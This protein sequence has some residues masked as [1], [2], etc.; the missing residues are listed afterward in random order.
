[1]KNR[2]FD[3]PNLKLTPELREKILNLRRSL[4]YDLNILH[5]KDKLEEEHNIHNISLSYETV[6]GLL[7]KERLCKAEKIGDFT[8]RLKRMPKVIR[9]YLALLLISSLSIVYNQTLVYTF[10]VYQTSFV[11]SIHLICTLLFESMAMEVSPP[12]SPSLS[13]VNVSQLPLTL[14]ACFKALFTSSSILSSLCFLTFFNRIIFSKI[15]FKYYQ[16]PPKSGKVRRGGSALL[17]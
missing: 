8:S 4:Y 12:T 15:K 5:F 6:R 11:C 16:H 10:F 2:Y 13:I 17:S 1:M 3:P 7:I 14:V 9:I